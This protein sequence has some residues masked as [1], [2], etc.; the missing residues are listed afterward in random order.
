MLDGHVALPLELRMPYKAKRQR[1]DQLHKEV[2]TKTYPG[3]PSKATKGRHVCTDNVDLAHVLLM[4]FE[5][6]GIG[7]LSSSS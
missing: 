7:S 4:P 6:K 3:L 2:D 1:L 5:E